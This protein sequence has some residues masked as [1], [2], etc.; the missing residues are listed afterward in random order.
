MQYSLVKMRSVFKGSAEAGADRSSGKAMRGSFFLMLGLVLSMA[1][2]DQAAFAQSRASSV[3]VPLQP[4]ELGPFAD[5]APKAPSERVKPSFKD[6]KFPLSEAANLAEIYELTGPLTDGQK[7]FLEEKRFILLPK[8]KFMLTRA[9]NTF[10][11]DEMLGN[12]DGLG[13]S[14]AEDGRKPENARYIGPD[15]I[16]HA[17]HRYTSNRLEALE[18]GPLRKNLVTMLTGLVQNA[19]QLKKKAGRTEADWERL[20]AQ[21]VV[22]LVILDNCFEVDDDDLVRPDTIDNA[23]Y[24]FDRYRPKFSPAMVGR[25]RDELRRIYRA[26]AKEES[27][28]GLV[29]VDGEKVLNYGRF[30]P[31]GHYTRLSASR[32]YYRAAVW[33][34][35]LG[36]DG[37]TDKGLAD[38]VNFALAMSYMP[39]EKPAEAGVAAGTAKKEAS[40]VAGAWARVVEIKSFFLGSPTGLSYRQWLR[41]LMKEAGVPEFT[42][43][44]GAN[45]EVIRRLKAAEAAAPVTSFGFDKSYELKIVSMLPRHVS[46]PRVVAGRLSRGPGERESLPAMFSALWIPAIWG[47]KAAGDMLPR[48]AALSVGTGMNRSPDEK[49][50]E[51]E[52]LSLRLAAIGKWFG[53][54]EAERITTLPLASLALL[55]TLSEEYGSG[56]PLYMRSRAFQIKRIETMSA[57][58]AELAHDTSSLNKPLSGAL[59]AAKPREPGQKSEIPPVVKGFVEPDHRFW[60][61]MI[62]LV[63]YLE[64][65]YRKYGLF[66]EDLENMGALSRFAKRLER[67]HA[68]SVKELRG[69]ELSNDDYEFIRLFSLDWMALPHGDGG[70]RRPVGQQ[71]S[72]L[73]SDI[74][75]VPGLTVD[76]Q[77]VIIYQATAEP[78]LML[79]LVGNEKSPRA[80][81]G[82]AYNHYEFAGPSSRRLTDEAWRK[83]VY[84]RYSQTPL[85]EGLGL[86][87]KNFWYESLY[88]AIEA[89]RPP[90]EAAS[91]S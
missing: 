6:K 1:W 36:W 23:L 22:P 53:E 69:E 91:N 81:L 79:V 39:P 80:A 2:A 30:K 86:P 17:F 77:G 21:L 18:A 65:G 83:V 75:T 9:E 38:A 31:A 4:V 7:S 68:L 45:P 49:K 51:S 87:A 15:V 67:C 71:R 66:P 50:K 85:P 61:E 55:R 26:S 46:L 16:L 44:T 24:I 52:V 19:E 12:F 74:R 84:G 35:G 34:E 5:I 47:N 63:S 25:I 10:P 57:F 64:A 70:G 37:R 32:A 89:E 82:L 56:Y 62:A 73:V 29:Q 59:P 33:L 20:M 76:G 27:L 13:G 72:A 54:H 14:L 28:L 60:G 11:A 78:W 43:D 3:P 48:Q 41:F 42:V 58:F 90:E 40:V 88:P 8:S